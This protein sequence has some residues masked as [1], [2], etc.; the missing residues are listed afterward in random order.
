MGAARFGPTRPAW[1]RRGR[2]WWPWI[3]ALC[4]VGVGLWLAIAGWQ[5]R[6]LRQPIPGGLGATGHIVGVNVNRDS[7]T[8]PYTAVVQFRDE[9]GKLIQFT[10]PATSYRP[11]IGTSVA[12]S[13][14]ASHPEHAHDLSVHGTTWQWAF[15]AGVAVGLAGLLLV[16]LRALLTRKHQQPGTSAAAQ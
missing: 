4:L 6:S 15:Y 14:S 7:L 16:G 1:F 3:V 5:Q 2:P 11:E 9:S 13:Y 10:P 12:V 8:N